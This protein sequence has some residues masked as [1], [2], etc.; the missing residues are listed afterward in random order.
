[1][2]VAAVNPQ[3]TFSGTTSGT[4]GP[5]SLVKSGS[6]ISFESNSHIKVFRFDSTTDTAPEELVEGT[7]YDLTG[8]P[9]AG[10]INLISSI[11]SA[12]L[13]TERLRVIRVQPFEQNADFESG[14]DFSSEELTERLDAMERQIQDLNREVGMSM[15]VFGFDVDAIPSTDMSIE[16]VLD[17]VLY[18]TGTASDPRL[19]VAD[20]LNTGA[21]STIEDNITDIQIVAADLSGADTIG[22]V[23]GDLAG[24]NN[25]GLVAQNMDHILSLTGTYDGEGTAGDGIEIVAGRISVSMTNL[26][27]I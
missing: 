13:D 3:I 18:I 12:L 24:D 22:T 27:D 16:N 21:F 2:S 26:E 15:R 4:Y 6:P 17:K 1:M 7:D 5:F 9:D 23:A 19:A 8:G 11:Q 20:I 10:I 25:I 14:Q